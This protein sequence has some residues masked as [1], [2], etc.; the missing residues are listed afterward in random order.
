M[1]KLISV[2]EIGERIANSLLDF[3][4]NEKSNEFIE[5]LK[6]Q[7]LRF[8]LSDELI[9]SMSD[10]LKDLTFVISGTFELHSRDEYKEM[11]LKNGGKNS[12]SVSKKTDFILAGKNMG[13]AKFDKAKKLGLKVIDEAAFLKMLS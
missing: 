2:E 12:G 4:R 8:T 10:K 6:L 13:P 3:F 9:E 5:R 7:G 11:I 1:S